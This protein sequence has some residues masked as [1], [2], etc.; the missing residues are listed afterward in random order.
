MRS[1]SV[2]I[3]VMVA[4]LSLASSQVLAVVEF[5]D[6]LIHD[7]DYEISDTVWVDYEAPGMQT[8]VNLIDGGKMFSYLKGFEDSKIN[9][10]GGLIIGFLMAEERCQVDISGGSI[11]NDVYA[12]GSR[13][14]VSGGWIGAL[15]VAFS[16][17]VHISGGWIEGN[18]VL[19]DQSIVTINGSNFAVN[20]RSV[21]YGELTSI[22][23]VRHL[24]GTLTCGGPIDINFYINNDAK[25]LLAPPGDLDYDGDVD[26]VDFS[27]LACQWHQ[28]GGLVS[29]DIAPCGGDGIVDF[30]DL[31][32]FCEYWLEGQ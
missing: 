3:W 29:A 20:G 11:S 30:L 21:G 4:A 22:L 31:A 16:S 12:Y 1:K 24:T 7:I 19:S 32:V 25:I 13:L 27:I 23:G 17:Q 8:T 14:T 18:L 6:G 15:W 2:M 26:L 9:I 10:F 28:P 5:K